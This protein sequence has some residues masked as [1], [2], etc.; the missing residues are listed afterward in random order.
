MSL[1]LDRIDINILNILQKNART[2]DTEISRKIHL[3]PNA[4]SVRIKR[5]EDDG[6]IGH[7][8][9]VL[10]KSKVNRNLECFTGINLTQNNYQTV[11]SFLKCINSMPEVYRLYWIN[12]MF[13]FLIHIVSI[14]VED[15]YDLL[16]NKITKINCV[17]NATPLI[18]FNEMAGLNMI[19]LSHILRPLK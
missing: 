7:Y 5:L 3:S 16:V 8:T 13:D 9:T 14:D 15:Y 2:S 10:N 6:Y 11:I 1:E 12:S 17:K 19:D 4:V 18:V